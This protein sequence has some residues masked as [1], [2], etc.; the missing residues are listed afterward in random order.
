MMKSYIKSKIHYKARNR[1]NIRKFPPYL[2]RSA[3]KESL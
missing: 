1:Q 3:P 2:E